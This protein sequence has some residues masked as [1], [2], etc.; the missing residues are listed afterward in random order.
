[1]TPLPW[2]DSKGT[3]KPPGAR[4]GK[5]RSL[6]PQLASTGSD[7]PGKPGPG[8]CTLLFHD[9]P[10]QCL[11]VPEE[12]DWGCSTPFCDWRGKPGLGKQCP[13]LAQLASA[14][15]D[16]LSGGRCISCIPFFHSGIPK[17]RTGTGEPGPGRCAPPSFTTIFFRPG[18]ALW[19]QVVVVGPLSSIAELCNDR[20]ALGSQAWKD[21]L[22]L[23]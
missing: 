3:N 14:G 6:L 11:I 21:A 7:M 10:L 22:P 19:S 23:P 4:L 18:Q 12:L 2:L 13:S 16:R 15:L 9:C 5:L 20:K 8:R 1:M 17:C